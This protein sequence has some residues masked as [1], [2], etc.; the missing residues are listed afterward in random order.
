MSM[1]AARLRRARQMTRINQRS[2]ESRAA[3]AAFLFFGP[4]NLERV[5]I[6]KPIPTPLPAPCGAE[7]RRRGG[8]PEVR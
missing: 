7:A 5:M 8:A 6:A 2:S 3:S 4:E 1:F